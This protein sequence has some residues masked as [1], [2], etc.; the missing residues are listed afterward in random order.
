MQ[1]VHDE[2]SCE[3]DLQKTEKSLN[4]LFEKKLEEYDED[5]EELINDELEHN[6]ED[7]I[8]NY[9]IPE[10]SKISKILSD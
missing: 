8:E 2:S 6:L 10:E 3:Q 1:T 5:E 7:S 9:E 4:K